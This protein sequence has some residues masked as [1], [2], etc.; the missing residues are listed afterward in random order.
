MAK[1]NIPNSN[2]TQVELQQKNT[3][4][5]AGIYQG[6]LPLPSIMEG[7]KN[8]DPSFPERIM[9]EFEKNSEH[10]RKGE[11]QAQKYAIERDIRGQWMAFILTLCL[12]AIIFF[13]LYLG[14]MTFAGVGGLVF[15]VWIIRT[16]NVRVGKPTINSK[17]QRNK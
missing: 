10:Y 16:F 13:A 8:I 5:H 12:M 1:K 17:N 2:H 11:E 4:L 14:N 6:P 3:E 9:K 15:I 7:Y